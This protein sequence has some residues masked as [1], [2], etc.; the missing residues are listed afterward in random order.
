MVIKKDGRRVPWN[1]EKILAG[2]ERSCFK[3][4][5]SEVDIIRVVDEV[6][7][8]VKGVYDREVPSTAVG[9]LVIERLRRLDQVAYVRF[10]SVYREFKT[11]DD[12]VAEAKAVI[13]ARHYDDLPGQGKLFVEPA[14]RSNGHPPSEG[15]TAAD[16]GDVPNKRPRKPRKKNVEEGPALAVPVKDGT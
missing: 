7:E 3:R 5:V 10:A 8:E 14:T 6:E 11:L 15:S 16:N 2:L 12:L 1:R 13:D 9:Q 4:P